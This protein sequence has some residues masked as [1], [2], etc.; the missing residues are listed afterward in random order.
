MIACSVNEE[1]VAESESFGLY[2]RDRY[3]VVEYICLEK[4]KSYSYFTK[5][6]NELKLRT[7]NKWNFALQDRESRILLSKFDYFISSRKYAKTPFGMSTSILFSYA[8]KTVVIRMDSDDHFQD[9]IKVDSVC[10]N[11]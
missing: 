1:N 11:F 9:F 6:K 3:S 7:T 10:I 8:K 5:E 4:N 2:K